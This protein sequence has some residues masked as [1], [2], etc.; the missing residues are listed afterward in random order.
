M[1][2]IISII[3]LGIFVLLAGAIGNGTNGF[4]L[5]ATI[6]FF[7]AAI[8][9]YFAPSW[10]AHTRAHPNMAGLAVLNLLLGWTVLGWVA[11]L[12][13][14]FSRK[15]AVERGP[16]DDRPAWDAHVAPPPQAPA[17][18]L[19]AGDDMKTCPFCAEAIKVA[20]IKCKHCGSDLTTSIAAQH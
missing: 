12:V 2:E 5:F 7:P 9:F 16:I 14:A 6:L 11:T 8:A 3:V 10:V 13:W 17:A 4:A 15:G 19:V 1:R 18:P 20:A